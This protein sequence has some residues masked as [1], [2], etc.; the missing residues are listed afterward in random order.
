[1]R[2]FFTFL[3]L[4]LFAAAVWSQQSTIGT[5]GGSGGQ[6]ASANLTNWSNIGTG[7]VVYVSQFQMYTNG[8]KSQFQAGSLVLTNLAGVG[9]TNLFLFTTSGNGTLP[10]W[11]LLNTNMLRT[12]TNNF[13]VFVT[14]GVATNVIDMSLA[15]STNIL[16]GSLT[17]VHATNG[18]SSFERTHVRWFWAGGS[19]R[20]FAIPSTWK[21]NVYSA[22][23]A[24]ITNGTITKMYVTTI[25]DTSSSANQTNVFVS[26]EFYK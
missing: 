9:N 25:G 12:V 17:M 22:V 24:N 4:V 18:V 23:P 1:M 10:D 8:V 21:T 6:P 15:S 2:K 13:S 16:N 20:A 11:S 7:E 19:D 26:F 14:A 3:A 5:G